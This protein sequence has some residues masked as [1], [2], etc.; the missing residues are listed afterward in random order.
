MVMLAA[1]LTHFAFE[2][3]RLGD[4]VQSNQR[5]ASDLVQDV[6]GQVEPLPTVGTMNS[7]HLYTNITLR[8]V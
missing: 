5:R 6:W 7:G 3:Q 1:L 2:S 4:L 8:Y